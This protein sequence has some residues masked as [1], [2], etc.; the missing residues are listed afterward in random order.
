MNKRVEWIDE[1][2]GFIL[3]LVCIGHTHL[4]STL[5][6]TGLA[7]STAFRM[8]TF[9]FLSG[10]LFSTRKHNTFKSY[11][12]SKKKS[13]LYPYIC[14]SLTFM[15][16]D[17]RLWNIN[18]IPF[19]NII[20]YDYYELCNIS[21]PIDNQFEYLC[22]NLFC[23]FFIGDSSPITGPLWFVLVLFITSIFFYLIHNI[24]KGN[25][26]YILL[27]AIIC[28]SLGW[29]TNSTELPF[30]LA[31]VFTASFFFS[32]GYLLKEYL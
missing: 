17:P 14:L 5:L 19:D 3:L 6:G 1:L 7:I 4:N 23:I 11:Y 13:L 10:I 12:Q 29:M 25:N 9:F 8:T 30:K 32:I 31:S 16:I 24:C 18:Y 21:F 20:N 22:M 2:K 28:L 15:L 26:L 27:Y